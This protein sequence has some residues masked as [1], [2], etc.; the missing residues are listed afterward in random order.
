MTEEQIKQIIKSNYDNHDIEFNEYTCKDCSER[1]RCEW[2]F[3]S[4]NINNDCLAEK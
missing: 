2:A 1:Y 3:S 4:Y